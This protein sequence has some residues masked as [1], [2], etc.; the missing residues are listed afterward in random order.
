[1]KKILFSLVVLF[2]ALPLSGCAM[3]GID[4][5]ERKVTNL[6]DRMDSLESSGRSISAGEQT[7][8]ESL[9]YVSS[10]STSK[11]STRKS[12]S[13]LM[14]KKEVQ[15]A[16]RDAGYY[17]GPIDGKLGRKSTQAIKEF[18]TDNGLKIDGVAGTQTIKAL[19]NYSYGK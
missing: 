15:T 11:S 2:V 13:S 5:L 4:G 10:G 3:F 16:L 17:Y 12:S 1:M 19:L 6:E 7:G 14:T 9:T 8:G 18:Q